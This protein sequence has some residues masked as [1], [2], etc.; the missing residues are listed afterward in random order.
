M[1]LVY[2]R[3]DQPRPQQLTCDKRTCCQ[4]GDKQRTVVVLNMFEMYW[5]LMTMKNP[6]RYAG[7]PQDNNGL[8][9]K[10]L[11]ILFDW[12]PRDRRDQQ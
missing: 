9:C 2:N 3:E 5:F 10:M 11:W 12:L 1:T 6:T 7:R 8:R 4:E